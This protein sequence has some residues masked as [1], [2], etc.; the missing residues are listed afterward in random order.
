MLLAEEMSKCTSVYSV[1]DDGDRFGHRLSVDSYEYRE[2]F[3]LSEPMHTIVVCSRWSAIEVE[4]GDRILS[5][6]G[7]ESYLFSYLCQRQLLA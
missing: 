3:I 1:S 2:V 4:H 6:S 5:E 7:I